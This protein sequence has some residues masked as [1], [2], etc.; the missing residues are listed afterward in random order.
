MH[1]TIR[2]L[3]ILI[4]GCGSCG[5]AIPASA[6][7]NVLLITADD[8]GPMLSC[9]GDPHIQTPHI[10]ALAASGV[11]FTTAYVAQAS[12]SPSRASIFT[13]LFP[14]THGQIGL[15]KSYNPPLHEQFR[16]QTLPKLMQ[17]AGY[18]TGIIGKLHVSPNSAVQFDVHRKDLNAVDGGP[19]NV[20]AMAK[21]ARE[22]IDADTGHPFLLMVSYVDPHRGD[23]NGFPTQVDGLPELPFRGGDVPAWPFQGIDDPAQLAHIADY[24][25]CIRRLDIGVGLLLD[26]VRSAGHA[27]DTL[28]IFVGDHGPPFDRGKTSCY[29]AG[30]RVPFIVRWPGVG[31][32][33][34]VSEAL[35]STTDILPT[36]LEAAE[37]TVPNHVQGRSLRPVVMGNGTTDATAAGWRTTLAGEFHMHGGRP[38]FPR[39]AVRDARYK[40]IHNLRAGQDHAFVGID[41][42]PAAQMVQA[43]RYQGTPAAA[44]LAR[45]ADP[46]EWELYDLQDD[47]NETKNL[48]AD[49]AHAETLVRMQKALL[50]WRRQT[51]DPLL[52]SAVVE[53]MAAAAP[54]PGPREVVP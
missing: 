44:A 10:D 39:R 12:C 28:V 31:Q 27:D 35:V 7:P 45:L 20:R 25:N 19:R 29:E 2:R 38:F 6:R 30:L 46:P 22:F 37:A 53:A 8:L 36:I 21:M 13:G 9:Y 33:G 51:A 50:D 42:D 16:S 48:A 41:G 5:V 54:E 11:R 17:A 26:E 3:L 18:R 23:G 43:D 4:L 14:H 1:A 52:D 32:A 15:A 34:L 24:Y 40:V 49:P 47:P